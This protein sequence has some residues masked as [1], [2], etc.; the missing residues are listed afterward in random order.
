MG[1]RMGQGGADIPVCDWSSAFHTG[2]TPVLHWKPRCPVPGSPGSKMQA[3]SF[4]VR[5]QSFGLR[6]RIRIKGLERDWA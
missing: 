2:E 5:I 1:R 3:S 6:T 4:D